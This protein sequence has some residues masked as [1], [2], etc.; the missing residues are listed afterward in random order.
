MCGGETAEVLKVLRAVED[1]VGLVTG[2]AGGIGRA[3]ALALAREGA[4]GVV[5]NDLPSRRADGEE[6]VRLIEK[7]GGRARFVAGDVTRAADQQALVT[8]TVEAFGRLDFAHNNA[9]VEYHATIPD[10]DEAEF[11]RIID[12]NLKGVWLGMKYQIPQML[13]Q[14][15][16]AIV[17]TASLAGLLAVPALGAYIASKFGVVGLTKTAALEF[18]REGIRVN[19]VCP[20]AIRTYMVEHLP[21]ER[22]MELVA[23]QAMRRLGEPN[24]VAE[25][26]VWL[27][28]DRASFVTGIAMPVDAGST[29]G[30]TLR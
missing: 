9:G 29:A 1:K 20:A 26:V 27:C 13:S 6:T 15:G 11:D 16:G 30:V 18:A 25:A 12:V 4:A 24:E 2:A 21:P 10:T 28:S 14:G 5:V 19:C 3:T 22:Q 23:P 7:D 8:A 17:N